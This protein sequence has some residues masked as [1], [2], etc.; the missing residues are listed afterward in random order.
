MPNH[1]ERLNS[2][3]C[4]T[5]DAVWIT[6]AGQDAL[7]D[8]SRVDLGTVGASSEPLKAI[9]DNGVRFLV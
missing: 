3:L 8:Q 9:D 5:G 6:V 4:L 1:C 2:A 7:V